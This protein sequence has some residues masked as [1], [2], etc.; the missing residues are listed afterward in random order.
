LPDSDRSVDEARVVILDESEDYRYADLFRVVRARLRFRLF[1]GRM[2][3]PVTRLSF[4]RGDSV[5]VL[6]HD[7][8]KNTVVLVRQFRYPV[9][10]GLDP[11]SRVTEGADQAW[12]L[13]IVAG[14]QDKGEG[15]EDVAHRELLE[16]V[17]LRMRGD[18]QPIATVY[19]SPGGTSEQIHLFLG[20]VESQGRDGC[21]GGVPSEGEDIRV[22]VLPLDEA[23]RMISC[24]KIRDAKT[25]IALQHLALGQTLRKGEA[26]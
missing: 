7:P 8:A 23:L 9:Y 4:E 21:T 25:V 24:G 22:E 18:L 1:G 16:E 26:I 2:S 10:A 17:G 13:E 12:L 19:P 6:L 11:E 14:V 20:E 15:V 5:A 3:S